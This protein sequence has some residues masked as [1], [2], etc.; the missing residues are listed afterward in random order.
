MVLSGSSVPPPSNS[1]QHA[2]EL[3][4]LA[5]ATGTVGLAISELSKS[6][7]QLLLY[8]S[9]VPQ[10]TLKPP[11]N[12][13]NSYLYLHL[14]LHLH[15]YPFKAALSIS[16]LKQPKNGR[17]GTVGTRLQRCRELGI[18]WQLP[19]AMLRALVLV[20]GACEPRVPLRAV[21]MYP[22]HL[23]QCAHICIYR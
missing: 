3:R 9:A 2:Q 18:R 22:C 17:P 11:L 19:A 16:L 15:L 20:A 5:T 21:P 13:R 1:L 6:V 14:P 7:P 10:L 23:I 8:H 12:S 4:Q